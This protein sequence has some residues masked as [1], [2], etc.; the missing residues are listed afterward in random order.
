M[1]Q[2]VTREWGQIGLCIF[3]L[4]IIWV[5]PYPAE[6]TTIVWVVAPF[7]ILYK[8]TLIVWIKRQFAKLEDIQ[9]PENN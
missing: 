4:I 2:L 1:K 9:K 6:D 8:V 3:I 5:N 7:F